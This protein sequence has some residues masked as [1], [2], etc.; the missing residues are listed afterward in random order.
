MSCAG[1]LSLFFSNLGTLD[2]S[3]QDPAGRPKRDINTIL[4][5]LNDLLVAS[6][7]LRESSSGL[8]RSFDQHTMHSSPVIGK[9]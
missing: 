4:Q 8:Q 7:Q 6:P 2:P 1:F 9:K 5:I 3:I